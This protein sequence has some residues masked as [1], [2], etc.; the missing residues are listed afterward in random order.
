MLTENIKE[1]LIEQSGK[2]ISDGYSK[3]DADI[4]AIEIIM[5]QYPN[6]HWFECRKTLDVESS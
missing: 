5:H 6:V 3:N 2:L 4:L 1:A